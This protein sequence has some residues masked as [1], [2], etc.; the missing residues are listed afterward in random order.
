[1]KGAL[2]IITLCAL[3][4]GCASEL[5][6]KKSAVNNAHSLQE[7]RDVLLKYSATIGWPAD[8]EREGYLKYGAET[9]AFL[10]GLV[11]TC[12]ADEYRDCVKKYYDAAWKLA[13][14]EDRRKCFLDTECKKNTIVSE[15]QE[16]L[17]KWYYILI[18]N[19]QFQT[20]EADR[21]ARMICDAVTKSQNAGMPYD[22]TENIIRRISGIEPVNR[23]MLIKIGNACWDLS[24]Y[25]YDPITLIR[26]VM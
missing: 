22:Q 11:S 16:E 23:E 12:Y 17:N 8:N 3:L 2:V 6:K 20:G 19:N 18:A 13:Y 24:H 21:T 5:E 26:P 9:D 25:G 10:S 7:K 15:A 4:V 1:M 14:K